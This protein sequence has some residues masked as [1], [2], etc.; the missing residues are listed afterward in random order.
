MS[1][2]MKPELQ[3]ASNWN[4]LGSAFSCNLRLSLAFR[5]TDLSRETSP[6]AGITKGMKLKGKRKP[7]FS[8][9]FSLFQIA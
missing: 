8:L 2:L 3:P 1:N 5:R 9:L 6:G 7:F 4:F